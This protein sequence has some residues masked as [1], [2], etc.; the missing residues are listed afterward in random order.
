[1]QI[2]LSTLEIRILLK[3]SQGLMSKSTFSQLSRQ[4]GKAKKDKALNNLIKRGYILAKELPRLDSNK[5]PVFYEITAK[6]Q[7]WVDYY[8]ANY[9]KEK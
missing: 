9:P 1:M 2:D 3:C 4:D 7:T 6:G 8:I 5:I